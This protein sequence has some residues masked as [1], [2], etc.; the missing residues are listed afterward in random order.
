MTHPAGKSDGLDWG[1]YESSK[2]AGMLLF[3]LSRSIIYCSR[4]VLK[5]HQEMFICWFSRVQNVVT[6]LNVDWVRVGG[7]GQLKG[8][9]VLRSTVQ[10]AC[11][12]VGCG[13][14]YG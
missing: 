1:L 10:P 14:S 2:T 13:S 4:F 8:S 9:G 11:F 3:E 6:S 12:S 7:S 5:A